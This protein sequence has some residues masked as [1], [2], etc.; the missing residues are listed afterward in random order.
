V[1][2]ERNHDKPQRGEREATTDSYRLYSKLKKR[3]HFQS[4]ASD[5]YQDIASIAVAEVTD[6]ARPRN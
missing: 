1:G 5:S 4:I 6:S 3:L 2:T